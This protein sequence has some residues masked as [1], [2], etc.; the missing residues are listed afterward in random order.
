MTPT[1]GAVAPKLKPVQNTVLDLTTFENVTLEKDLEFAPVTSV[2]E[3]SERLGND[4]SKLL[5]VINDGLEAEARR[6]ARKDPN[7]W[8]ALNDDDERVPFTGTPANAKVVN[9]MVLTLA[10]SVFGFSKDLSKDAKA[11][12]K[13]SARNLIKSTP[14]ILEGLKKSA[15]LTVEDGE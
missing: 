5:K 14:A 6:Q 2:S 11:A 8:S 7:G 3:A 4:A 15:A 12:S 10:K 9:G 13:E 1:N